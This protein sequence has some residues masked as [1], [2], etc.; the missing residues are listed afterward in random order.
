MVHAQIVLVPGYN[1]GAELDRTLGD[2]ATLV[3]GVRSIAVVPVGLTRFTRDETLRT[4]RPDEAADVLAQLAP[5]RARFLASEGRPTVM[6]S[7]EWYLLAGVD[8]PPAETYDGFPQIENGVGLVRQ[9]LDAMQAVASQADRASRSAEPSTEEPETAPLPRADG[10]TIKLVTGALARPIVARLAQSLA[11]ETGA[12]VRE[13]VVPSLFWGEQV[14][15]VGLLTGQDL[16]EGLSELQADF[17]LVPD[18]VL[19][20]DAR[21]LDDHSVDW[22]RKQVPSRIDFVSPE[23]TGLRRALRE[24]LGEGL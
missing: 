9:L 19:N 4:W 16:A 18:L 2:L 13:L 21:F 22:L 5:W 6:P 14:T 12:D 24:L 20:E 17:V 23:L 11:E 3:P 15:V 7:D 1:D 8:P 10:L